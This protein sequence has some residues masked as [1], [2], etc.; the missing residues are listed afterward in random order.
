MLY[1]KIRDK[2]RDC[3]DTMSLRIRILTALTIMIELIVLIYVYFQGTSPDLWRS[4]WKYVISAWTVFGAGLTSGLLV[5]WREVRYLKKDLHLRIIVKK[6]HHV[7]DVEEN[8]RRVVME[9]GKMWYVIPHQAAVNTILGLLSYLLS[10]MT[11]AGSIQCGSDSECS[12]RVQTTNILIGSAEWVAT[13]LLGIYS[14]FTLI[15]KNHFS[16]VASGKV[17]IERHTPERKC[18]EKKISRL[19]A[20]KHVH[21]EGLGPATTSYALTGQTGHTEISPV[22]VS[23]LEQLGWTG[24]IDGN[25]AVMTGTYNAF[26]SLEHTYSKGTDNYLA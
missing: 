11:Y 24:D 21:F 2:K 16:N 15:S 14:Y 17:I 22:K 25:G 12:S 4:N 18:L 20:T 5:G 1:N 3:L 8:L 19:I 10:I 26:K 13:I 7:D 6:P 9:E 23:E